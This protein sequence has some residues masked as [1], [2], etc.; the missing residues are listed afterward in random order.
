MT[1]K[2]DDVTSLLRKL[3]KTVEASIDKG[4]DRVLARM[5][6]EGKEATAQE[7]RHHAE[8]VRNQQKRDMEDKSRQ[9][10]REI[11][12]RMETQNQIKGWTAFQYKTYMTLNNAGNRIERIV[13]SID[14]SF[15]QSID[16]FKKMVGT[17]LDG[18]LRTFTGPFYGLIKNTG[19]ILFR[20]LSK[21]LAGPIALS[22]QLASDFKNKTKQFLSKFSITDAIRNQTN[23]LGEKLLGKMP[24][25][26]L[27][28]VFKSKPD[29]GK[30]RPELNVKDILMNILKAQ[31]ITANAII[32]AIYNA[33]DMV[34]GAPQFSALNSPNPEPFLDTD[35]NRFKMPGRDISP[36]FYTQFDKMH[37][38]LRETLMFMSDNLDKIKTM[39][40]RGEGGEGGGMMDTL[41]DASNILDFLN[42]DGGGKRGKGKGRFGKLGKW[43]KAG[44]F[45]KFAGAGVAAGALAGGFEA[46]SEY[47]ES[48]KTGKSK[49]ESSGRA[50]SHGAISFGSAGI[51]A[52]L[53][54]A[55][56]AIGGP[57]GVAIGATIGGTVGGVLGEKLGNLSSDLGEKLGSGLFDAKEAIGDKFTGISTSVKSTFNKLGAQFKGIPKFVKEKIDG[58]IPSGT[59]IVDAL[60]G[61]LTSFM[62]A[63]TVVK[64]F[65]VNTARSAAD[66]ATNVADKTVKA[67]SISMDKVSGQVKGLKMG[68][69]NWKADMNGVNAELTKRLQAAAA[70]YKKATGKDLVV[71]E[72]IRTAAQ[73]EWLRKN[74]KYPTA[75]GRSLHQDGLAIDIDAA[76]ADE[77]DRLGLLKKH[78]LARPV[79]NDPVHLEMAEYTGHRGHVALRKKL[80]Q[81]EAD[82]KKQQVAANK[83][84]PQVAANK[85]K[86]QVAAAGKPKV[87]MAATGAFV[88]KEGAVHLH[89]GEIV[90]PIGKFTDMLAKTATN[91]AQP[92]A[93]SAV[94]SSGIGGSDAE[95]VKY[96]AAIAQGIQ[97]I[98]GMNGTN[99]SIQKPVPDAPGDPSVLYAGNYYN[100]KGS[101]WG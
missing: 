45:G 39:L 82:R 99:Q 1:K 30:A 5:G 66:V 46:F 61:I 38:F 64:N 25:I 97:K 42:G 16:D 34:R 49:L 6:S 10:R 69:K 11:E 77:M 31:A 24:R 29:A 2:T 44:K 37:D 87:P 20:G 83:P 40:E 17:N 22:Q 68:G 23:K 74:G 91:V 100:Q 41:G 54:G 81:E 84:K 43:A 14:N 73:Q 33:A 93:T 95:V 47:G 3:N 62:Q 8:I 28:A 101:Q 71:T 85:P 32:D 94:Q 76:Q 89:P 60:K 80:A 75:K 59:N 19:S 15:K 50:A 90:S 53:G 48:R 58:F 56:G 55:A 78:K 26:S 13:Q 4:F 96:L 51:G 70:D 79:A 7:N 27:P 98:V 12:R 57:I 86:P 92:I 9:M 72:G 21:G 36:V 18:I 52:M 88:K 63:G 65:A 35:V 67:A